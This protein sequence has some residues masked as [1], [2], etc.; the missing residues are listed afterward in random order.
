MSLLNK[1]ALRSSF[2]LLD[3][4]DFLCGSIKDAEFSSSDEIIKIDL[5]NWTR[6]FKNCVILF[7]LLVKSMT[8]SCVEV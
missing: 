7:Y 3:R 5:L 6:L 8:L 1:Q 2:E 4:H